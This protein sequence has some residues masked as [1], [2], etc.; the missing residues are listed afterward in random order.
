MWKTNTTKIKRLAML[1]LIVSIWYNCLS[2][3]RQERLEHTAK[4]LPPP[5]E[6]VEPLKVGGCWRKQSTVGEQIRY[7]DSK[8]MGLVFMT[9]S[10]NSFES[11]FAYVKRLLLLEKCILF[12]LPWPWDAMTR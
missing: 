7:V 3:G 5:S 11:A 2:R 6:W 9:K 12:G 8:V 4:P 1:G 10:Y